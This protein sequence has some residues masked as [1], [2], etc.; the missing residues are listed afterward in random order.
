MLN[1]SPPVRAAKTQKMPNFMG[2]ALHWHVGWALCQQG[3]VF[4]RALAEL[5]V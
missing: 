2:G 5:N 1:D 3:A 4:D